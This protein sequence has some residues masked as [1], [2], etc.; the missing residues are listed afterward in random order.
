MNRR[1]GRLRSDLCDMREARN[2]TRR[3]VA[4]FVGVTE[5]AVWKWET[6]QMFPGK[7][8]RQLLADL[9]RITESELL[10]RR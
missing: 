7:R 3:D 10:E 6:G 2:M 8:S 1:R 9:Y 5:C 4:D